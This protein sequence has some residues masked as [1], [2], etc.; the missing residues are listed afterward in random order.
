MSYKTTEE[1]IE[2]LCDNGIL[3]SG[4]KQKRQ[5]IN[6]GY[7]HGY[8]G[9]RYYKNIQTKLPFKSYNEVYSTIQYDSDIKAL[10]YPKLMYIEMA[11]KN[12]AL[13]SILVNAQ[14]ENINDMYNKVVS[15]YINAPK[16][17]NDELKKKFQQNKLNLQKKIDSYIASAY[18][19]QN[20]KITHYYNNTNNSSHSGVP[21]W[22]LFEIMTLGDFAYLL[23]CLTHDVRKDISKKI[24]I[25]LSCDTEIQLVYRYIYTLKDLRNEVAHNGVVFDTR[26]KKFDPSPSMKQCLKQEFKLK[27]VNFKTIGDYVILICYYLKILDIPKD[28]I[29]E[30]IDNLQTIVNKYKSSVNQN[31]SKIVIHPDLP[32]RMMEIKKSLQ[33]SN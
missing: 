19:K 24:G 5:L 28:E 33:N 14:S 30:F 11:V 9:Y 4:E 12:I 27:Y 23:S 21:I 17:C 2:Y 13:E 1:L 32:Y 26:F 10:L 7:Y 25:N 22:A 16:N 29:I 20:D 15:S 31:V 8:K 6:T 3:I 18:E